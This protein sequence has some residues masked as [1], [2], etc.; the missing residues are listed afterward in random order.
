M[1]NTTKFLEDKLDLIV[2]KEKSK[3]VHYIKS[4]F[5]GFGFYKHNGKCNITIS[6][7][8]KSKFKLRIKQ[9]TKRNRDRSIEQIIYELNEY[10][11]GW[12]HY[13]KVTNNT[14]YF[15]EPDSWVRRKIRVYIWKQWKKI[16]TRYKNLV[17][18][19]IDESK[20]W[21]F[22]NTR[23]GLWR[24]SKSPILNRTLTNK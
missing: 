23:K 7:K 3:V 10:T 22:A 24:I 2:N 12:V 6:K 5:L 15:I 17:S 4:A 18:L 14:W 19:D 8:S 1:K 9:I 21:E 16:K 20:A 11:T 13:F